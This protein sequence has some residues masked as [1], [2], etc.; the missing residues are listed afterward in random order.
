MGVEESLGTD[1]E[2]R[3]SSNGAVVGSLGRTTTSELPLG[4]A[5]PSFWA[6]LL[7]SLS[8]LAEALAEV[9]VRAAT[10]AAPAAAAAV[11]PATPVATF[12]VLLALT[13]WA[14]GVAL[15][16]AS[17]SNSSWLRHPSATKMAA[18]PVRFR[19][20]LLAGLAA[21]GVAVD[22]DDPAAAFSS[23]TIVLVVALAPTSL[24]SALTAFASPVVL[25]TTSATVS[26]LLSTAVAGTLS[27][28]TS[29]AVSVEVMLLMG[30]EGSTAESGTV[31]DSAGVASTS[32][33]G[34][35]M[36]GGAVGAGA[37]LVVVEDIDGRGAAGCLGRGGGG[38]RG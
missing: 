13:A 10:T 9:S 1:G 21:R 16:G 33:A 35:G 14:G 25:G 20:F 38:V 6:P 2:G 37:V 8:L 15:L 7:P 36:T 17:S 3:T 28:A 22:E 5:L 11:A 23:A 29:A 24:T 30:A 31:L 32:T 18:M 4:V 26:T 27:L 34:A 19:L 12:V